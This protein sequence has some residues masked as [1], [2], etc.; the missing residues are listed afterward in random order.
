MSDLK[1]I[2]SRFFTRPAVKVYRTLLLIAN[3]VAGALTIASAYGGI[4]DP[5]I[6]VIPALLSMMLPGFLI[7]G[8]LLVPVDFLSRRGKWSLIIVAAW[9]ISLPPLL[10]YS[11][12]NISV[13]SLT[14][15]ERERTFSLLTYNVLNLYDFR[16]EIDTITRNATLDY[17]LS[18]DADIVSMQEL[19]TV[20][21]WPLW[22]IT[23]EQI[24]EL[25]H[26]YPYR[27][28]NVSNQL[29]VLS[30]YPFTQVKL[31]VPAE[32]GIRMA[33]F[34]FDI[35]GETVHL[36]NVHL[37]SIG[38]SMADKDLYENLFRKA[39]Q[40][41]RALRCEMK[42]VKNQLISKLAAAFRLR[43]EQADII[44][45][46]IDSIGGNFIVAGD[47]NDIQDSYAV[48]TILGD[49]LHDAYADCALGPCITYHGN[50]FY[51]RIDHMLYGG[52][53]EAVSC[54]RGNILSSDHFPLL[55]EFLLTSPTLSQ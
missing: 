5:R 8:L 9:L 2:A 11:P 19:E 39:P 47:F 27:A 15:A 6:T 54:R 22:K 25:K 18:T 29:T 37:E 50:K 35:K 43:A 7:G 1:S 46:A 49:D 4:P 31:N 23:A 38:L 32:H 52:D 33:L 13:R 53:L 30:R 34:R 14:P 45:H 51:F 44:R 17:I 28:V 10:D 42:D 41:E 3:L 12:V 20:Q 16:G 21:T 55:G 26:R 36:F 48:R 40:S 24:D